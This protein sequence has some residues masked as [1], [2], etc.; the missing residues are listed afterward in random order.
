MPPRSTSPRL[1]ADHWPVLVF[2][3]LLALNIALKQRF[4]LFDLRTLCANALP[5]A[6]IALGQY[7]VV[8]TRGIDLSLGPI[9]SLAGAVLSLT[10]GDN[11]ALGLAA[12]V[13]IGAVAGLANGVLVARYRFPAIIVTLATMTVWQGVALVVLP[14]PGGFVPPEIQRLATRG[15]WFP[16]TPLILL[17]LTMI[18]AGWVMSSRFGLHLRAIGGDEAAATMSGVRA[19]RT[20]ILAYTLA[21]VM[22]GLGGAYLALATASGS[23]TIGDD[24][25]LSSVATVVVGGVALSG[26]RGLTSGVVFGALI[27]TII[28]SLLYSAGISSF[29]QSM[30]TG[31]ILVAVVAGGSA[32]TWLKSRSEGLRH[33]A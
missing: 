25:I 9:A 15:L 22:A 33:A 14:N 21:G 7:F 6:L 10:I 13:V 28:G 23:P 29:Y 12:P 19:T 5:L 24:Y 30:L 11:L 32:Q 3:A 2:V 20:T 27:L 18:G 31:L 8:M 1:L 26:G 4:S 16:P 17:A